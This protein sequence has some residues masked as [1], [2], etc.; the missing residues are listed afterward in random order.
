MDLPPSLSG[1][2]SFPNFQKGKMDWLVSK[3]KKDVPIKSA[4]LNER[5]ARLQSVKRNATSCQRD[6]KRDRGSLDRL[7]KSLVIL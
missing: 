2:L 1:N 5:N 6:L 3:I 7:E 4:T